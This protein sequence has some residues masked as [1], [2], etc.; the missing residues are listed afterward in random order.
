[1]CC[2]ARGIND[3]H[4]RDLI[5]FCHEQRSFIKC[6]HMIPLTETWEPGE[7]ETDVATTTEDVEQIVAAGFPDEKVEFLSAGLAD[8]LKTAVQVLRHR[9]P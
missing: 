1:M 6:M 2:V 8:R 4:M 5:D 7:F 9:D 3:K